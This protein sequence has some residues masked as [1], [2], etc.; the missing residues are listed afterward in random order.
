MSLFAKTILWIVAL[1][2]AYGAI[3]HIMNIASLTGFEWLE[4]PLK[5][6]ALDVFYLVLDIVVAVGF[7]ARWLIATLAF[8]IAA[9][10]QIFLYTILREWIIDVP[11]EFEVSPEQ[12]EYLDYLVI[13]HI[14]TIFLVSFALWSM[15]KKTS[16]QGAS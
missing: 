16:H 11:K 6:Q 13:F 1:F 14:S 7:F 8:Y 3:V 12:V 10:S 5:W 2:Y 4:A 9:V 15:R